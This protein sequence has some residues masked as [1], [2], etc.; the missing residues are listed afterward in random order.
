MQDTLHALS[1]S[2]PASLQS[3]FI[4]CIF[5]IKET[6]F[7]KKINIEL[8]YDS[9]ILLLFWVDTKRN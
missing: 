6:G 9:E 5:K 2:L 8:S 4:F 1:L 3:N 7:F